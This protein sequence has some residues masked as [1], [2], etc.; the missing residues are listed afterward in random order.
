MCEIRERE[1]CVWLN[2]GCAQER[3]HMHLKSEKSNIG[4]RSDTLNSISLKEFQDLDMEQ[5]EKLSMNRRIMV[6]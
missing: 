3:E 6:E 2:Y 4:W 5:H 1:S